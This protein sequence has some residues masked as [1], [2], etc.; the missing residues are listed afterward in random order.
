MKTQ[1]FVIAALFA[2]VQSIK[3]RESAEESPDC[4]E[5]TETFPQNEWSS[6]SSAGLA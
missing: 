4:P 1:A 6:Y 2:T 3:L 5:S